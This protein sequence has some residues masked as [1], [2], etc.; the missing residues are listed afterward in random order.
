M[1]VVTCMYLSKFMLAITI[2][3]VGSLPQLHKASDTKKRIWRAND[4][5]GVMQREL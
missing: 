4:I 3:G 2:T 1:Q 5:Y